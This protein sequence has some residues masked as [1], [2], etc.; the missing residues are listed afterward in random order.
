MAPLVLLVEGLVA[1]FISASVPR[2][3]SMVFSSSPSCVVEV[4]VDMRPPVVVFVVD[5]HKIRSVTHKDSDIG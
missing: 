4:V 5:I 3:V 1:F 2:V